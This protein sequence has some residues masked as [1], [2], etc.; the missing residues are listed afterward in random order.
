MQVCSESMMP[1]WMIRVLALALVA[2]ALTWAG[3]DANSVAGAATGAQRCTNPVLALDAN[4][5]SGG[6]A[7]VADGDDPTANFA[8]RSTAA[9]GAIAY[10]PGLDRL[11]A[12]ERLDLDVR[13]LSS[14]AGNAKLAVNWYTGTP[15]GS[16]Y[17]GHE[18]GAVTPIPV[19]R[20]YQTVRSVVVVPP[21][22]VSA[23]LT[24]MGEQ[25]PSGTTHQL[26]GCSYRTADACSRPLNAASLSRGTWGVVR[27]TS[28]G[29]QSWGRW[30]VTPSAGQAMVWTPE[31]RVAVGERWTFAMAA[32]SSR[33]TT[34]K[35]NVSWYDASTNPPTYRSTTYGEATPLGRGRPERMVVNTAQVPPIKIQNPNATGA[36]VIARPVLVADVGDGGDVY[37]GDCRFSRDAVPTSAAARLGW[38]NP[39]SLGTDEFSGTTVDTSRWMVPGTIAEGCWPGHGANGA[40]QGNGRRCRENV[41]VANGLLTLSGTDGIGQAGRTGWLGSK[42]SSQYGKWEARVRTY[43]VDASG[44]RVPAWGEDQQYRS[45][46]LLWP[47]TVWPDGGEYDFFEPHYPGADCSVA[48][49][50]YPH[51]ASVPTQQ[52]YF[53]EQN[54]GAPL[55]EWHVIGF[56]WTPQYL[57]GFIDG[58]EVYRWADG[59][60]YDASGK[61]IRQ[62]IQTMP[63]GSLTIQLDGMLFDDTRGNQAARF[64]IDWIRTYR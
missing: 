32:A 26:T 43:D 27:G 34:A 61:L 50:H 7:R 35:F 33:D 24:L 10:L 28:S 53:L 9:N 8:Y 12:G 5:W 15:S 62:N 13:V 30:L 52:E 4:G 29:M 17:A 3:S 42:Y 55:S 59:A 56:E 48:F 37:L 41:T 11:V 64:D 1:R 63:S 54:C 6:S 57:R 44:N 39:V 19:E 16:T 46:M 47:T 36:G 49:G 18:F 23:R 58:V 22:V 60:Q 25:F 20:S 40:Y 14:A 2:V 31:A 21:G 38:T 51:P 45:I